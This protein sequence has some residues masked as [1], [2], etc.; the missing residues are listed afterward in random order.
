MDLLDR[1]D[2]LDQKDQ[3]A[4]LD[5]W[6]RVPSFLLQQTRELH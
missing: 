1:M 2:L 4:P 6:L 3:M 5:Q